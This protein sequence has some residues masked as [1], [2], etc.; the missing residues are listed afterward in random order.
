[1]FV[2]TQVKGVQVLFPERVK[3]LLQI[4]V[5]VV[6]QVYDV[7]FTV[8]GALVSTTGRQAALSFPGVPSFDV[9][10][11]KAVPIIKNNASNAV[12][13]AEVIFVFMLLIFVFVN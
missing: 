5:P 11:V 13:A 4:L 8:L 6:P 1:M 10:P 2:N 12:L 9:L 3:E 7:T